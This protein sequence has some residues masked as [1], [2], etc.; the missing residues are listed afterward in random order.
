VGMSLFTDTFCSIVELLEALGVRRI[1]R[2][3]RC[4]THCFDGWL[5]ALNG[6]GADADVRLEERAGAFTVQ[7]GHILIA[8][9][10]EPIAY[11]TPFSE[12]EGSRFD[13]LREVFEVALAAEIGRAQGL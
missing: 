1:H 7:P 9:R 3:T 11:C 5:V 10:G 2:W 6:S 8:Y 12:P 13:A 4:W